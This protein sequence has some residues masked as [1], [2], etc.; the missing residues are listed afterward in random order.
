[1]K[2]FCYNLLKTEEFLMHKPSYIQQAKAKIEVLRAI[3]RNKKHVKGR[4]QSI[5]AVISLLEN[6]D[7]KDKVL[8]QALE[9]YRKSYP[10]PEL[11]HLF[12]FLIKDIEIKNFKHCSSIPKKF[13]SIYTEYKNQY[14]LLTSVNLFSH[15]IHCFFLS[16]EHAKKLPSVIREEISIL[17][18][19]HDF[20][21]CPDIVKVFARNQRERHNE[22]SANY[23]EGIC[24]A[25]KIPE[26]ISERMV[27]TLRQHHGDEG[28]TLFIKNLNEIDRSA[29]AK[30]MA[31]IT[32]HR[33]KDYI[34][35]T[36]EYSE[37]GVL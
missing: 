15:T 30:E 6:V 18:L 7:L 33:A 8:L 26:N 37:A 12:L 34:N 32:S 10:Q 16:L 29:R 2:S 1:M 25:L 22:V 11:L 3:A 24:R 14:D 28:S 19:A 31:M 9:A 27:T 35:Q 4:K 21:K 5:D 13:E 17:A 20:G 23:L 36:Q